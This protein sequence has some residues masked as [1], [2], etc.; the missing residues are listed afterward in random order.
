MGQ[1]CPL[2]ATEA[3]MGMLTAAKAELCNQMGSMGKVHWYKVA[4]T[5]PDNAM[6]FLEVDLWD[7][8]GAFT[9]GAA[10]TGTFPVDTDYDSCGVCVHGLGGT[11]TAQKEYFATG[12]MVT[13]GQ[14]GAAG[15]PIQVSISNDAF[16]EVDATEHKAVASGCTATLAAATLTGT[17][18][19]V[20]GSGGGGGGG[21]GGGMGCSANIGQ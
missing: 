1:S 21:G 18:M 2:A 3:D 10:K 12:G 14:I 20:G 19:Q 9:G 7:Q 16:A 8:D 17:L 5:F 11:G 13:V 15:T 4:A 6:N